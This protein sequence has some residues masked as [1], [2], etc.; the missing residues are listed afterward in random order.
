M[1][2]YVEWLNNIKAKALYDWL[3]DS[4]RKAY[5]QIVSKWK[6]STFICLFGPQGCGKSFLARL[7]VREKGY[8]YENEIQNVE[9][10][11]PKVIIDGEEYSR[12]MRPIVMLNEIKRVVVIMRRS[13]KDP[14]PSVEIILT[15]H[16]IK[17][18]QHNL[19]KHGVITSFVTDAEGTDLGQ[20]LRKEAI[21]RGE[22]Y[23]T[24]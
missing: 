21:A 15:E 2:L 24:S 17:Q 5:D 12:L 4:Q 11:T 9:P 1:S 6:G 14:M 18:F 3:T 13:P 23:V 10:G 7:L 22:Y 20:I 8:T 19:T 16:D